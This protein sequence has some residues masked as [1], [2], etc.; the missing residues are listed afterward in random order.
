MGSKALN[1]APEHEN[2]RVLLVEPA[3]YDSQLHVEKLLKK[4]LLESDLAISPRAAMSVMQFRQALSAPFAVTFFGIVLVDSEI[5]PD[6]ARAIAA[7]ARRA[8]GAAQRGGVSLVVSMLPSGA[9]APRE[10]E[11]GVLRRASAEQL[12]Q[13]ACDVAVVRPLKSATVDRLLQLY[14]TRLAE[15]HS[16]AAQDNVTH[17]GF[18][19]GDVVREINRAWAEAG[20]GR[21]LE[22]GFKLG[23]QLTASNTV[24][25]GVRLQY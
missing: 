21:F 17:Y 6:E 24:F 23:M 1:V 20:Q 12:A 9:V 3:R 2:P 10:T 4:M 5:A 19:K 16:Q 18:K 13:G 14:E 15:V 22:E 11:E 25:R 7:L 8:A